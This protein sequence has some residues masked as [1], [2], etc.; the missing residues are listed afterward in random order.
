MATILARR[1]ADGTIGEDVL[2]AS[3]SGAR[4]RE[5]E[6]ENPAALV[7]A[8]A[9][10]VPLA[11]LFRWY[12]DSFQHISKWQRTNQSQLRFLEKRPIGSLNALSLS[13]ATLIDHV[14]F[15]ASKGHQVQ[16]LLATI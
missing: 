6:L 15:A 7:R 13:A 10:D 1:R 3:R 14:R 9:G 4:A 12:I 5:V 11:S 16:R 2:A 8:C